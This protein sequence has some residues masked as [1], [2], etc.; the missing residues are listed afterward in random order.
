MQSNP[1]VQ[2]SPTGPNTSLY[3]QDL[4]AWAA[5]NAQLLRNGQFNELDIEHLIE[6]LDDMGKSEKRGI[7]SHQK[8]LLMHLLKWKTQ[9]A[10]RS[11][12]WA[13]TIRTQR[14]EIASLLRQSP[15]LRPKLAPEFATN[16]AET[17]VDA[18]SDMGISRDQLPRDCRFNLDQTLDREFLPG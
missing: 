2:S 13:G 7:Y 12:S 14:R 9:P 5:H 6:E 11:T 15:S 16:Y 8:V 1:Q 4:S 3:D 18:S 10:M 17:A